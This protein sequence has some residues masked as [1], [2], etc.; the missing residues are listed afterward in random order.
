MT[1]CPD[2]FDPERASPD[3][4]STSPYPQE[5]GALDPFQ[6]GAV[7]GIEQGW[8]VDAA[9]SAERTGWHWGLTA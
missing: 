3:G 5:C 7:V 4:P 2:T 9:Q 8:A 1:L 6:L